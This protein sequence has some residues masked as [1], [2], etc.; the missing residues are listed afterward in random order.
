MGTCIFFFFLIFGNN[1]ESCC[2]HQCT[3]YLVDIYFHSSWANTRRKIVGSYVVYI[4]L[5]KKQ[6]NCLLMWLYHYA[7]MHY[8]FFLFML[9]PAFVVAS[10]FDHSNSC[11]VVS[12]CFNFHFSDDIRCETSFHMLICNL[13]I[14]SGEISIKVFGSIFKSGCQFLFVCL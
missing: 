11:I 13:F 7:S 12:H 14:F 2:E 5:Y 1:E 4:S 6:P 10:C 9:S 8:S 3:G